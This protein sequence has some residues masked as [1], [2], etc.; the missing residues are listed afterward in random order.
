LGPQRETLAE[1]YDREAAMVGR[2]HRAG[3]PLLAG[4]DAPAAYLPP[5]VSLHRELQALVED[6]GLTPLDAI[7]TATLNA[8]RYFGSSEIGRLAVGGP[9]DLVVLDA[10]PTASIRNTE[11]I[12]AVVRA[13]R[14]LDRQ[15]L[16]GM[17]TT[18]RRAL[19]R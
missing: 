3:V 7:R 6:S 19:S 17:L 13:G 5:G 10:D 9:A 14:Y 11:R 2:M 12:R 1:L 15:A 8:G 16:D 18:A 4:T